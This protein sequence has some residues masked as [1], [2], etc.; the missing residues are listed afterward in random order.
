MKTSFQ[1]DR[2]TLVMIGLLAASRLLPHWPNATPVAAMALVGG[3]LF[4]SRRTAILVPLI[5]MLL[6]DI[7]MGLV[8]GAEYALHAAQPFV[9][10]CFL[11]TAMLGHAM[12]KQSVT[13]LVLLGGTVSSV[14][15]FLVTN[16]A[17]WYGSTMYSQDVTGLLASYAAGLAFYEHGGNF[18]LNH[19]V[20]TWAFSAL[21]LAAHAWL[22]RRRTSTS[23]VH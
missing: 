11:G 7:A 12:R 5:A 14:V 21:T 22:T 19:L 23:L 3:A 8:F 10:A 16:A 13:R 4:A 6:S 15:F 18:F 17:A 20:S 1:I 2:S 9:Y